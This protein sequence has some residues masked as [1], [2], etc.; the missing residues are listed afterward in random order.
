MAVIIVDPEDAPAARPL[1]P[2]ALEIVAMAVFD[3][4]QITELVRSCVLESEKVP[5]AVNCWVVPFAI[6]GLV[7]VTAIETKVAFVTTKLAAPDTESNVA[8]IVVEPEDTPVARP[9]LPGA[10]EI[11]ALPVFDEDQITEFVRSCVLESE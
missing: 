1:L 8:V 11:V 7:G 3:E 6:D 2:D 9:L 4:V 10:L 5:I